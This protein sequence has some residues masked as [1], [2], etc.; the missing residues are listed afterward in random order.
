LGFGSPAGWFGGG[1]GYGGNTGNGI[2]GIGGGG[3]GGYN[4][5]GSSGSTNTG[6]GGGAS[7][8]PLAG[9]SGGSGII[10]LSY[11]INTGSV[12]LNATPS[13]IS[14]SI[15]NTDVN[16][17]FAGGPLGL[18]MTSRTGSRAYSVSKNKVIFNYT[19]SASS[20]ISN[21]LLLN[22][23]NVNGTASF[24]S[25]NNV[26]YASVGAG[27]SN[28]ET[29]TYYDLVDAFQTN[30]G[31]R[32]SNPGAFITL[33]DTRLTGSGTSNSSSVVLPLFG[34]QAITASWGDGTTSIISSSAQAD[35]TH[36]YNTPGRYLI[37]ITGS[38]QG[39]QFN[40]SGDKTKLLD[41]GQWGSISASST[42][43]F[44]GCSNLLGTAA[45][46]P[47]ITTTGLNNTFATARKFNGSIG[48]WNLSGVT[49][50]TR[51]FAGTDAF[52][53]NIGSWN[54]SNV[55]SM[56][57]MFNEAF[58][59]NNGGSPDINNWNTSNVTDMQELFYYAVSF[60]QNIGSWNV[61]KVTTMSSAFLITAFNNSGSNTIN[62]WR[63]I[64]CS[65]FSNICKFLP[66]LFSFILY[67]YRII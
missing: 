45:D 33:W 50:L 15:N 39:F 48:N 61:S 53:Q 67:I 34:T 58:A 26:A 20:S 27:L 6:G 29:R 57:R 14:G 24:T 21:N 38:G 54:T 2:G 52:N 4:T 66:K 11:P 43:I 41:I 49:N 17:F 60:N 18:V 47:P 65:N 1:G 35:R 44:S 62:N 40:D 23:V 3:D 36:V 37:T 7:V 42:G 51:M 5:S 12:L 46:Y 32:V 31:R 63:P 56:Q 8:F 16:G 59:F 10:I 25:Q 22:A 64:S 30:L 28:D 19:S 55:T 13:D 9:G